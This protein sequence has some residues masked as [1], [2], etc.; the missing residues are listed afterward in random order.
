ML[1]VSIRPQNEEELLKDFA[2]ADALADFVEVRVD[3][4]D[5]LPVDLLKKLFK[6]PTIASIG[7]LQ[8]ANLL[9][10]L[11]SLH[12]TWLD[13]P[14]TIPLVATLKSRHPELKIITSY[15]DFDKTPDNLE[16][17][18]KQLQTLG[19]DKI[20][21]VVQANC[22]LDGLKL[23]HFLKR[24]KKPLTSFCMG[25]NGSFTRVLAPLYGSEITYSCL[26]EKETAPGQ[27]SCH[28]LLFI[29][30]FRKLSEKTKPFALIG[31]PIAQSPSFITHNALF[32]KIGFD[33]VYV[34]IPLG[35]EEIKQSLPLIESLGFQGLSVTHPLKAAITDSIYNTVGWKDGQAHYLNTDGKGLLDA[36]EM[37]GSVKD[38]KVVLLG[39]G[40]TGQAIAQEAKKR[41][42]HLTIT[43]RTEAKA[44]LFSKLLNCHYFPW[45]LS[46]LLAMPYDILI[47]AT[48]VGMHQESLPL[49]KQHIRKEAIV[50]DVIL[51]ADTPFLQMAREQGAKV[52]TGYE[53]WFR[54]AAYQFCFWK[55]DL[56]YEEVLEWLKA[57][58]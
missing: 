21:L 4:F 16:E 48:T 49:S 2:K 19:G 8:E 37:H 50:A 10:R 3:G 6:R 26:P 57:S 31:K 20:K 38:K 36:I 45:N 53:M 15:H 1:C 41:G 23:L 34:K 18:F 56:K 39:A 52:V 25:E 40:A 43:N 44:Y 28:E 42:A 7:T 35:S 32:E 12:P 30:H 27:L 51:N 47:N 13:V 46:H 24:Q 54:Q 11:A 22:G 5:K 55:E 58:L 17:I 33:A 29:Y 9:E 14:S